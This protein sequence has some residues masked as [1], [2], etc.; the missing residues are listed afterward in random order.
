M[1]RHDAE[2]D[3]VDN[4]TLFPGRGWNATEDPGALLLP[5][6]V[7]TVP[8]NGYISPVLVLFTLTVN[9]VVCAVLLRPGLFSCV[10]IQLRIFGSKYCGYNMLIK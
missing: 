9:T 7:W 5:T 4:G 2:V 1:S 6:N 8:V 10:T 3:R